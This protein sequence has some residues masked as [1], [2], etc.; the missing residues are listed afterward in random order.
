MAPK[1]SFALLLVALVGGARAGFLA[2]G[3]LAGGPGYL[4][5][6]ADPYF[7]PHPQYNFAYSVSD[8]L[9]GDSKSQQESRNGD[10]VQGS[11]SLVEPD[12]HVRTV[13][14]SADAVNGFNAVVQRTGAGR[15]LAPAAPVA[16]VAKF[17]APAVAV[18]PVAKFAA[19]APLLRRPAGFGGYG[20]GGYGAGGYGYGHA[21]ASTSFAGPYAAYHY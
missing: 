7:D 10:A 20:A 15:A 2:G 4:A 12:G 1:C 6:R 5:G 16:A 14:Y 11:Y 13:H 9:T 19:A 8:G 21:A 18:A 3:H 17:A